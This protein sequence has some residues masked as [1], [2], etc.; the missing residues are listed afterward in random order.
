MCARVWLCAAAAAVRFNSCRNDLNA[1]VY[2]KPNTYYTPNIII[3]ILYRSPVWIPFSNACV[4]AFLHSPRRRRRL[5][6]D[7]WSITQSKLSNDTL[8]LSR[9]ISVVS[10]RRQ[11]LGHLSTRS[12]GFFFFNYLVN[13]CTNKRWSCL[14]RNFQ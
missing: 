1:Y 2:G 4:S 6:N 14:I 12:N 7:L 5:T 8:W 11:I 9:W 13:Y 10:F 3:I